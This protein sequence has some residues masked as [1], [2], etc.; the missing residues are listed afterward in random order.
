MGWMSVMSRLFAAAVATI[1]VLMGAPVPSA[2][3]A[4]CPDIEIVF[5]RGTGEKPGI[6]GIGLGF[7][8]AVRSKVGPKS[9][10]VFAVDY[11]ASTD[12]PTAAVGINHAADHIESMATTCPF[13]RMVLGG[14]SQ[15]AAVMGY[16]TSAVKPDG[17]AVTVRDPLPASVAEH[18]AAIALFGKPSPKFLNAI[19]APPIVIGPQYVDKTTD[20]CVSDDPIC[21]DHGNGAAHGSYVINGMANQAA[22]F[23]V[24]RL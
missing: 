20:L 3:A 10:S 19:G 11:P 8:D 12:F 16:V 13:T 4:P 23:A 24:G 17:V 21:A 9:L 7:V 6:G 14:H 22:T 5:A 2:S 18:V 15:G 1:G